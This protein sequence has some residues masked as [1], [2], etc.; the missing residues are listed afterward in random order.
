MNWMEIQALSLCFIVLVL[1]EMRF[2]F[3]SLV[4]DYESVL[5]SFAKQSYENAAVVRNETDET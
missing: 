5:D 1:Q 4:S 3:G 2:L